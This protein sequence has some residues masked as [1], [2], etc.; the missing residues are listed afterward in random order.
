LG[1]PLYKSSVTIAFEA[2]MA[3]FSL[4]AAMTGIPEATNKTASSYSTASSTM[5]SD[6]GSGIPAE[7]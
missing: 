6:T 2:V 5:L 1:L 7:I 3:G 4:D